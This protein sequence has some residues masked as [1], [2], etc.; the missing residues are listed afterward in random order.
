MNNP[1]HEEITK[2]LDPVANLYD[3]VVVGHE[4]G[5]SGTPHLQGYISFKIRYRLATCKKLFPKAHWEPMNGTPQQASDYCK[6]DGKYYEDGTLPQSAQQQRVAAASK[7]GKATAANYARMIELC[8]QRKPNLVK[9]EFP[10]EYFRYYHTVKRIMMDNPPELEDLPELKNEW[11]WGVPGIGKS[12]L[13]RHENPGCYVKLHNKWWLGYKNEPVVL[14]DDLDKSEANWIGAF[15]KQW[16]DHYPFPSETKG[17]GQVIR[18]EK[19]VVTSNY[20]IEDVF[21]EAELQAAIKRRF[22]VRHIVTAPTFPK[23]VPIVPV[24]AIPVADLNPGNVD[25]A[26]PDDASIEIEDSPLYSDT[27]G[28]NSEDSISV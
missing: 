6:K 15:L 28:D 1:P 2:N 22:K 4:V 18:P 12:R 19:I 11:I 24:P 8:E 23:V 25:L 9:Q 7:G 14:Y 20:P 3:Y 21:E 10:S 27:D 5:E 17:D 26:I 16:A 13:A